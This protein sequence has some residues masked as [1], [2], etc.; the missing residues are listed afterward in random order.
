MLSCTKENNLN[1]FKSK[2]YSLMTKFDNKHE[3]KTFGVKIYT[4][5]V[6]FMPSVY[7]LRFSFSVLTGLAP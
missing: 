4:S 5:H 7:Q 1:N 3:F 2:K 6:T